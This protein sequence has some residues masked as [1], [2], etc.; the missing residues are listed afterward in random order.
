MVHLKRL[1]CAA[2]NIAPVVIS[3]RRREP[4]QLFDVGL[5]STGIRSTQ[6]VLLVTIASLAPLSIGRLAKILVTGGSNAVASGLRCGGIDMSSTN[7]RAALIRGLAFPEIGLPEI[8]RGKYKLRILWNLGSGSLRF[9]ALRK[10]LTKGSAS[11]KGVAPRVLSRDLKSLVDLGLIQRKAYDVVPP[12][13]EYRLTA[14]GRTA[15]PVILEILKWGTKHP[16]RHTA[17]KEV[18]CVPRPSVVDASRTYSAP[19][20]QNPC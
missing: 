15:L 10:E 19:T 11:A 5:K 12:K 8:L 1:T 16:P 7:A 14:L 6:F 13:V 4:S 2:R 17:V 18:S 9:G 20:V 3:E